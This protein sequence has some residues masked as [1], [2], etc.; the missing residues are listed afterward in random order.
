M[1]VHQVRGDKSRGETSYERGVAMPMFLGATSKVILAQLPDRTLGPFT[2]PMRNAFA[3]CCEPTTG[4]NLKAS[5][6]TFA[7]LDLR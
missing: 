3:N 5:S 2:S 4:A 7:A 6:G 1:C